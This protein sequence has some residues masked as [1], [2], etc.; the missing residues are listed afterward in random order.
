[1]HS[2][3]RGHRTVS[4]HTCTYEVGRLD[5]TAHAHVYLSIYVQVGG[6][7]QGNSIL[8]AWIIARR[9]SRAY[10]PDIVELYFS[11]VFLARECGG[12]TRRWDTLGWLVGINRGYT[13]CN[14]MTTREG[15]AECVGINHAWLNLLS[16][17]IGRWKN[18]PPAKSVIPLHRKRCSLSDGPRTSDIHTP[19]TKRTPWL[20]L[21]REYFSLKNGCVPSP[22]SG[23]C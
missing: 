4:A 9:L 22:S 14:T 23:N 15:P 17:Y 18:G 13:P 5:E 8:C 19:N 11:G 21:R 16:A 20:I 12:E 10:A 2:R 1:M 3:A 6:S 7:C